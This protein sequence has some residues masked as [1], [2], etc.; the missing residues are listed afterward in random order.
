MTMRRTIEMVS[1]TEMVMKIR[2]GG[3]Y[4]DADADA[5]GDGDG[6]SNG[7]GYFQSCELASWHRVSH[8]LFK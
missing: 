1:E 5:D 3:T 8:I 7:D 2:D 6:D 4:A